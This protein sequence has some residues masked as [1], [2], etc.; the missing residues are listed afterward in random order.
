MQVLWVYA[1]PEPCSFNASLRDAGISELTEHGHEVVLRDLYAMGW[2]AALDRQDL[3]DL[4]DPPAELTR[5][6]KRAFEAGTLAPEVRQAQQD[7]RW[8]D[9]LVLQFPLWWYS[10]PAILKGWIDRVFT[11]GFAYGIADP[12]HP[13][14]TFRYGD[15]PL[16]GRR[17]QVIVSTGSP[18][19]AMSDRGINGPL[20]E[21]LFH[22]LHGTLWYVG[23]APLPPLGIHGADRVLAADH[24]AAVEL[25]RTRMRALDTVAPLAYRAQND[26]DYDDDLVLHPHLV[27]GRRGISVHLHDGA[28]PQAQG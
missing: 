10:T 4:P 3:G 26:G 27:P 14:R 5:A 16:A 6:S 19:A 2:K 28:E 1:H 15:G 13:G 25:V 9:T 11:K 18:A 17:A 24:A 23:L 22:L 20:D 21:V 8:A 7:L 12:D